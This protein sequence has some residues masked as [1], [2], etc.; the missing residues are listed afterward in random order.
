MPNY[1]RWTK[2]KLPREGWIGKTWILILKNKNFNHR[3]DIRMRSNII[4][5]RGSSPSCT[6]CS[7]ECGIYF[8]SNI[9]WFEWRQ[10]REL[11]EGE[12]KTNRKQNNINGCGDLFTVVQFP[13]KPTSLLR[14]PNGLGLFQPSQVI[15]QIK[16]ESSLYSDERVKSLRGTPQHLEALA[17]F[18]IKRSQNSK[19]KS[20]RTQQHTLLYLSHKALPLFQCSKHLNLAL[21]RLWI[22]GS[23]ALVYGLEF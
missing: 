2:W 5:V 12:G 3:I 15:P 22:N 1:I 14:C 6:C 19:L 9:K 7:Y 23:V 4:R 10:A 16:L 8:W 11:G 13:M 21:G 18:T 20:T 17:S